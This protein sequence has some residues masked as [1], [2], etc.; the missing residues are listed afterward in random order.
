[1]YSRDHALLSAALGLV[2]AA[3]APPTASPVLLWAFV[4]AL[5]VGIDADHFLV[6]RL[7]RGDWANLRRCLSNPRLVVLD[8]ESIFEAGDL[9]RDQRLLSHA[10]LGGALVAALWPVAGYWAVTA[11]V[12]VY[13]HVVADLYADARTRAAY[14]RQG[15]RV[16]GE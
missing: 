2:V 4:V 3:L 15:A 9:W 6:A 8:Q 7:E 1:M 5:G 11:A 12:T 14:L 16:A 10:L 13:V